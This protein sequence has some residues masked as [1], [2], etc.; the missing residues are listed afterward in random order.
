MKRQVPWIIG[1][2]FVLMASG[3][4]ASVFYASQKTITSSALSTQNIDT[5]IDTDS[6][7]N[8]YYAPING[9]SGAA[10]QSGLY[11]IIKTSSSIT[12]DEAKYA[13][14]ITDR[15]WDFSSLS[16]SQLANYDLSSSGTDDPYLYLLYGQYNNSV[17]TAYKW[18]SD[19]TYI[20][21][22]EH[23]WAKSH[24]NFSFEAPAGTDLH[25]LRAADQA[26]N[27]YHSNYDFGNADNTTVTPTMNYNAINCPD[28][29]GNIS[30]K[31][32]YLSNNISDK[33]YEPRD[34]DKGDVARMIF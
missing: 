30:G 10:L 27:D 7:V 2:S 34:E 29:R 32:G 24:G 8:A 17:S 1:L 26:N 28:E 12:Y 3:L 21:N 9:L 20:W 23:T 6:E 15:N 18:S 5:T 11:D 14:K 16:A 13:M 19:P 33:V 31:Q 22:K 25:H 4:S